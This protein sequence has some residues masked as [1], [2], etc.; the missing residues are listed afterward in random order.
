MFKPIQFMLVL[1]VLLLSVIFA[2]YQPVQADPMVTETAQLTAPDATMEVQFGLSVAISGETA[3]IGA[4]AAVDDAILTGATY[5]FTW[6][7]AAWMPAAKL[8]ASDGQ[9][10]DLFGAAVA[11]HD[12][13]IVVGAPSHDEA[14]ANSGAVYVFT[15][16]G[17]DWAESDKLLPSAVGDTFFG[18]SVALDNG[19]IAVGAP[20]S[21][22]GITNSGAAYVF[23]ADDDAWT[24]VARFATGGGGAVLSDLFGWAVALHGDL[25][26]VGA[27]LDDIAYLF[28]R[29]DMMGWQ[30][31]AVLSGDDT[32][33]GDRFGFSL[34]TNG[35]RVLVGAPHDN[36]A[37]TN[38]GSAYLFTFDGSDWQQEAKLLPTG[39]TPLNGATF[40]WSVGL[41]GE[42]AVIGA[43]NGEGVEDVEESGLAFL[44]EYDGADWLEA[45]TLTASDAAAFDH[46]G[47]AVS[48]TAAG[49]LVGAPDSDAAEQGAGAAYYFALDGAPPPPP[50]PPPPPGDV[51]VCLA[52]EQSSEEVLPGIT[53][54]WDSAFRCLN[55]PEEGVYEFNVIVEADADSTALAVVQAITLTHT[56]PRPLNV[57]P[58]ASVDDVT[59]LPFTIAAGEVHTF[60][61]SGEYELA[62][63]GVARLANLHFCATGYDDATG[64]P[65]YLGLNTFLRGS[66]F[67]NDD[68]GGLAQFV[69]VISQINVTPGPGIASISWRTDLPATS[70]VT[71]YPTDSPEQAQTVNRGCL[72]AETH[73]LPVS[74]LRPE[75]N[76]TFQVQSRTGLD[77]LAT[78]ETLTF[79]TPDFVQLYLPLA[80]R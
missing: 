36:D 27:H 57:A 28:N 15:Y 66:G 3:V 42:T 34:A 73:Q 67:G 69:P 25:L 65:F 74:G 11:I 61:V 63:A 17:S 59:G 18:F 55:A 49:V 46:L 26:L 30:E 12:N 72:V 4:P 75:T 31:T 80:R 64:T 47:T 23:E 54:T 60:T 37:G 79:T 68:L 1:T 5:V 24:E 43:P 45:D 6:D 10:G 53:L 14:G 8:V 77:G 35:V 22:S 20:Y 21:D 41:A 2:R 71:L 9:A 29:D 58:D 51:E 78:S 39:A 50:P 16:D 32:Q 52:E 7:G 62:A 76:Y 56:T 48:V 44:Y 70:A 40:G 38:A 13:H 19:A 33:T